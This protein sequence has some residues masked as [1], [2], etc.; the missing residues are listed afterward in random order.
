MQQLSLK[1]ENL[2]ESFI[3]Q[4]KEY[5]KKN[6]LT[7]YG[8]EKMQTFI[9]DASCNWYESVFEIGY[10]YTFFTCLSDRE[11]FY[12]NMISNFYYSIKKIDFEVFK[13]VWLE[14][15]KDY[16]WDVIFWIYHF[17]NN[18]DKNKQNR[19]WEN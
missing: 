1:I 11:E 10:Y 13:E 4:G 18:Y 14:A 6:L 9:N 19:L 2:V 16:F 12:K 8:S 5:K 3:F 7:P 15:E 17:S